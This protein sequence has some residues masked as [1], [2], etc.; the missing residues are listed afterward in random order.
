MLPVLY[1]LEAVVFVVLAWV[2]SAHFTVVIVLALALLDGV[3]ALTARALARAATVRRH[4]GRRPPA[5]GQRGRQ[6]RLLGV[7]HVRAGDWAARWSRPGGTSAAL[8][9]D[10]G[11]FGAHRASTLATARACP[12]PAAEPHPGPGP[13]ARRAR[14]RPDAAA[15]SRSACCCR[16]SRVLFFTISVPVE[17]VFAQHSLHAGAAGYG[18]TAVGLGSGRGGRRG[19]LRPVARAARPGT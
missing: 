1:W 2:A 14:L 7:L 3:V 12:S 4:L 8:L 19:D 6:R 5:G 13:R 17:V 18:A 16:R 10:A 11:L 15:D 9:V